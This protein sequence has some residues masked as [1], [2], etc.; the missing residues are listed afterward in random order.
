MVDDCSRATW[1]YLLTHKSHAFHVMKIFCA[2]VKN[3]FDTTIKVVKSDDALDF[4]SGPTGA[5][6]EQM[7]LFIGLPMWIG[8][9]RMVEWNASTDMS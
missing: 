1:I 8:P 5:Y 2:Y 7:V 4:G 6:F 3:Q 9:N